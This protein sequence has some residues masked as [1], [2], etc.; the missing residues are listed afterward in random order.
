[1]VKNHIRIESPTPPH[2]TKRRFNPHSLDWD[3]ERDSKSVGRYVCTFWA[4]RAKER[5]W[6]WRW[7]RSTPLETIS[8][9]GKQTETTMAMPSKRAQGGEPWM[10]SLPLNPR[11]PKLL[12]AYFLSLRAELQDKHAHLLP[13]RGSC[14][15]LPS[16]DLLEDLR[17]PLTRNSHSTYLICRIRG[18][19]LSSVSL[20]YKH[21]WQYYQSEISVRILV[22]AES[23]NNGKYALFS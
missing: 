19:L 6:T 23:I 5:K 4:E 22:Q 17:V 7:V 13:G 18:A 2:P 1:M 21:L 3:V 9:P 10:Q 12:N 20:P 11:D 16:S 15:F 14:S 8:R